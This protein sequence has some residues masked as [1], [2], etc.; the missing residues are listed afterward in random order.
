MRLSLETPRR[1]VI[2]QSL[3][4]TYDTTVGH[5]KNHDGSEQVR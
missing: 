4:G 2:V 5:P 1:E 3:L